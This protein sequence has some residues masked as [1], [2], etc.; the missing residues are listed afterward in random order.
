MEALVYMAILAVVSAVVVESVLFI[1][2]AFGRTRIERRLNLNGDIAIETMIRE[3]RA[4]S[5]TDPGSSLFGANPGVLKVGAK[6]FSVSG[7]SALQED[8]A[9]ITS[10][11]SVNNL[12]F[13][14]QATSTLSEIIK[15]ELTLSAGEG[16]FLKTKNFYGSAVL[17]GAY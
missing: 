4:S 15:I 7:A 11:V 5:N 3:I 9:D 2:K 1:Y 14:R 12:I 16:Q 17:R 10:D 8:G 6:T 13:Y